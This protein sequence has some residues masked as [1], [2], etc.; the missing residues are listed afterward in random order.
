MKK[1][2]ILMIGMSS[3]L[4][5]IETY[6]Y[7]LYRNAD[8]NIFQFDFTN[9]TEQDIVYKEELEKNGCQIFK[10]TPRYKNYKKHLED[11]KNIFKN[12]NYDYVHYNIMSFSWYE[13]IVI[14][15]KYSNARIIIHS[16]CS[17]SNYL[18]GNHFRTTLLNKVGKFKTRK[19]PYMKVACGQ[20]AGDYMFGK[21]NYTIFNNGVDLEKF[22]FNN[23]N[24]KKIRKELKIKDNITIF[25]LI[26]A[27]FPVKNHEFLIDIFYEILKIKKDSKLILIGEGPL[28]EK[29]KNKVN[30]LG[31]NNKVLFLGKRTDVDKIYSAL[32][33]YLMP[34]LAEGLSISLIEAQVNG[35]KCYTSNN[36]DKNSNITGNVEF[37]SLDQSSED[38]VKYILNQDNSRD[39][40]VLNKIPDEFNAKKSY[41]EVY[42][43]YQDNLK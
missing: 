26:A 17:S 16:H 30:S 19:I 12:N 5:G 35:L 3:N 13:P 40:K 8:K 10:L 6:L 21:S 29:I 32:D 34:S 22:K 23:S 36:V 27:F 18:K 1:I 25:G 31:I 14:A 9:V 37:L 33:V 20:Q 24:R 41:E 15:N 2:K 39:E 28:Q 42:K 4:G 38:W 11:L 7:N 43:F